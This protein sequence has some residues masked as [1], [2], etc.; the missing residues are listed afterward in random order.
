MKLATKVKTY[1]DEARLTGFSRLSSLALT[2]ENS[3]RVTLNR[4]VAKGEIYNPVKGTYVSK[5][6]DP[7]WAATILY[8]GYLTLS[9]AFYIHHLI[10]EY[11]FAVFVGSSVRKSVVMGNHT[12]VYFKAKDFL[13]LEKGEYSVASVEKAIC[14]S[15]R[16]GSMT[17]YPMLVR[18]LYSADIHYD[19]FIELCK[20][21]KNAF[22]QRLGY[23]LSLLPKLSR[24]KSRL[25]AL[26]KAK[27]KANT[28]L[29][30]RESGVYIKKWRIIDNVGEKVLMAW[31]L[32]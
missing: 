17:S 18:V 5:T 8:P 22:F 14:D 23:L 16:F 29:Q 19:K 12:F 15:L 32:Q 28:Y 24:E 1:I 20:D 7:L 9:T 6:A 13:G 27:V 26:C 4:L 31:W 21:E 11:P 10:D 30:G 25:M 2:S 3:L